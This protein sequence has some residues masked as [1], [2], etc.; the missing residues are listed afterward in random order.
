MALGRVLVVLRKLPGHLL[1]AV[2]GALRPGQRALLRR[3]QLDVAHGLKETEG[4]RTDWV[5]DRDAE[6]QSGTRRRSSPEILSQT[7]HIHTHWLLLL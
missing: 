2:R 4:E 6:D 7:K 5:K 1:P 3:Q